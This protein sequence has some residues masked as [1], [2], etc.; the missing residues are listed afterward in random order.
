[1]LGHGTTTLGFGATCP[2]NHLVMNSL[3]ESET[4]SLSQDGSRSLGSDVM[5]SEESP[6]ASGLRLKGQSF[7]RARKHATFLAAAGACQ[8]FLLLLLAS[9]I[10]FGAASACKTYFL[11][12]SATEACKLLWDEPTCTLYGERW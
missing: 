4:L 8:I 6:Q 11:S 7:V 5:T 12:P 1:M 3:L 9:G 2:S 10:P